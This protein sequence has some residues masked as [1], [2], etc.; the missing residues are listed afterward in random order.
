[1]T[2]HS[3]HY[4]PLGSSAQAGNP[5]QS[6]EGGGGHLCETVSIPLTKPACPAVYLPRV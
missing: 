2:A 5:S 1:M 6:N 4:D 3:S